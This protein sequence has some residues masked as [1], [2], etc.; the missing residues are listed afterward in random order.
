MRESRSKDKP[1]STTRKST[2]TTSPTP[3]RR[4]SS[5]KMNNAE[6]YAAVEVK[7]KTAK[8]E[9][10]YEM[11]ERGEHTSKTQ[12]RNFEKPDKPDDEKEHVRDNLSSLPPE[13]LQ[14]VAILM[15]LCMSSKFGTDRV[16]RFITRNSSGIGVWERTVFVKSE[17]I[18]WASWSV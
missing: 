13:D 14:N 3:R 11:A 15:L 5:R 10:R 12:Q 18:I 17:I 2:T 7:R 8:E 9:E 1:R 16:C 6:N 4:K